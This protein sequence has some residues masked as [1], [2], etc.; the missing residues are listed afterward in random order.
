MPVARRR[1]A[2][3]NMAKALI[4]GGAGFIGS[5]TADALIR[6]GWQ[7]RVLDCLDPQ[8]H[9]SDADFPAY[10]DPRVECVR[11]DVRDSQDVAKALDGIDAVYHLAA[12]TGVGQSMYEIASYVDVNCRG[13]ATLLEQIVRRKQKIKRLVLASSRA[14]YGEGTY[15]DSAGRTVHP[16]LRLRGDRERGVFGVLAEDGSELDPVPTSEDR[17]LSPISVY[18]VTKVQQEELCR[19]VAV[20]Y[21]IP[22]V[23]LR[24]FNVY[25][26]RQSLKNPYT[27]VVSVFYNR[28]LA[29]R[30]ISL[31]ERGLSGRDFVH[32]SDVAQANVLALDA[33]I[34]TGIAINVG[35]GHQSTILDVANALAQACR[36]QPVFED[37]GE[38]RLGDIRCCY[39]DIRRARRVLDYEPRTDLTQGMREF[40]DWAENQERVDLYAKTVA[41]LEQH[42]LFG[43]AK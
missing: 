27:G 16:Q 4:T 31:Y 36:R 41:E 26:S 12:L 22:A 43:I 14:V 18:G 29:G 38:F 17:P 8:I 5:H 19:H 30:P 11:G 23:C 13:T 34:E 2:T 25:G 39:A 28:L 6:F 10:L 37:R 9:G 42:N 33:E 40:A 21:G 3:D 7:V 1:K 20:T 35:T 15:V 24:Y 32:V